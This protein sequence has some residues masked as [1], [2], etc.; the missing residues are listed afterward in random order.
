MNLIKDEV[1]AYV[2]QI[3]IDSISCKLP[4]AGHAT[5]SKDQNEISRLTALLAKLPTHAFRTSH[6]AVDQFGSGNQYN[7]F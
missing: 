1:I 7:M 6:D 2:T 4:I 3:Q 5:K